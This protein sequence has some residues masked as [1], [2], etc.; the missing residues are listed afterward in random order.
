MLGVAAASMATAD[1]R[2]EM[3][4]VDVDGTIVARTV[5]PFQPGIFDLA[6]AR[7]GM[8]HLLADLDGP[9]R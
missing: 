7:Q 2:L 8:R 1:L 9:H 4:V 6:A 3:A 5:V